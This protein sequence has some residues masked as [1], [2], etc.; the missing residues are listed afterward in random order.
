MNTPQATPV[1]ASGQ[2]GPSLLRERGQTL[3][4]VA[5][6][7]VLLVAFLG[8]VI[9]GGNVYAQ[10]RQMQNAADAAALAGARAL[11][12]GKTDGE[13]VAAGKQ[14]A[15]ANGGTAAVTVTGHTTVT[16]V[17]TKSVTTYFANVIGVSQLTVGAAATAETSAP[18]SAIGIMPLTIHES[19]WEL[20]KQYQIWEKDCENKD[21]DPD[22]LC[23]PA[24]RGWLNLDAG[25]GSASDTSCWVCPDPTKCPPPPQIALPDGQDGIWINS[26]PGNME[27]AVKDLY[28]C[29][30]GKVVLVPVFSTMCERGS[31]GCPDVGNG[32]YNYYIV[33]FAALKVEGADKPNAPKVIFGEF[34]RYIPIGAAADEFKPP[35]YG[36][37]VVRLV[38]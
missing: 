9:D 27:S 13:A 18:S 17:V 33:G 22:V 5:V 15:A 28:T 6:M 38:H 30:L 19:K 12:M 29:H 1:A 23:A 4:V 7:I 14:Y 31:A 11:A 37:P 32:K 24:H 8:L 20:G 3:V 35:K 16:A 34:V 36:V 25:G 26:A 21:E 2:K 10:R